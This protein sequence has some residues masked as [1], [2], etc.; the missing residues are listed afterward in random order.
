MRINALTIRN[1]S[2]LGLF[3]T[4]LLI[5]CNHNPKNA[6]AANAATTG[7][8]AV[9]VNMEGNVFQIKQEDLEPK[10]KKIF[11]KDSIFLEFWEDGNPIRL[12]LNL[13]HTDI[14]EQGT[15]SFQIPE[16]NSPRIK[17]DLNFFNTERDVKRMNKRII[18]RK[19]SIEIKKL[20]NNRLEMTFEGEGSG[21]MD[22]N[23]TFPI[24]GNIMVNY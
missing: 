1:T 15:T 21:M 23:N 18:F 22:R 4:L 8:Y 13:T 12:N 16:D 3:L 14:L 24:S 5:S 10:M 7:N 6:I 11:K 17:A 9:E 19:G 2:I 20:T